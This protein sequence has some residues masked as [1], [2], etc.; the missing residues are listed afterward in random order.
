MPE[1]EHPCTNCP[2]AK[3]FCKKED[4]ECMTYKNWKREVKK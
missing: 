1:S 4:I 2:F 3:S